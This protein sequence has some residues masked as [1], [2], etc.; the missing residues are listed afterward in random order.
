MRGSG[1][2]VISLD[3]ELMWGF[4]GLNQDASLSEDGEEERRK[5]QTLIRILD[6]FDAPATWAVVGHLMISEC[7]GTHSELVHPEFPGDNDWYHT[8]PGTDISSDPLRYGTDVIKEIQNASVEHEIATHTFSHLYCNSLQIKK[9]VLNSELRKCRSLAESNGHELNSIVYPRNEVRFPELLSNHGIN[10]YR[11]RS[12]P[13]RNS[14][15]H[16][17][18]GI[19]RYAKFITGSRAPLV[20]PIKRYE[21][22]WEMPASQRLSY[23]PGSVLFNEVFSPHRRVKT[24]RKAIEKL[25]N[26]REVYHL[27]AH[28]HAFTP[29]MFRDLKQILNIASE[30][31]VQVVTMQQAL[32]HTTD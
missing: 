10:L 21:D 18:G 17:L 23:N 9:N 1:V 4:H 12:I 8:D 29:E 13:E 5:I 15:S 30:N 6:E 25:R 14:K 3:T 22:V 31:Q 26:R 19:S 2:V 24:A 28:P 32:K 7:D 27:W 16:F 11:S 20:T